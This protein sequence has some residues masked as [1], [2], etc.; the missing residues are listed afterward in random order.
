MNR[1]GTTTKLLASIAIVAFGAGPLSAQTGQVGYPPAKSPYVDLPFAQEFTF[2]GGQ[3]YAHRDIADV[4]PQSG[5]ITGVHYEWRAGGP[6]HITGEIAYISSDRRL[7]N[8][9]KSEPGRELGQ[10]ARPLYTAD[11]GLGMSLTGEKS[12]H[13]LVPEI[14][15]GVGLIS[16]LRSQPDSGGFLFGTRFTFNASAGLRYL[17]G[18][19]WQIRADLKDRLYTISY[20][21]TYFTA[22]AGGTAV[23]TSDQA[24][25]YWLNNPALTLGLSYL[26]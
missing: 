21:Q 12:W 24:K 7:I 26:F 16:D 5:M 25:S 19:K 17:V 3:Y 22:P 4:G 15:V 23:V 10:A 14:G 18:G 20:P 8:P 2:L 13:S 6:A 11:V 9:L 1:F